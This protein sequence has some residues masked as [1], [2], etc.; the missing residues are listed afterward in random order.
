MMKVSECLK[1]VIVVFAAAA[2][3]LSPAPGTA[4]TSLAVGKTASATGSAFFG[5]TN[6]ADSCGAIRT[7]VY[8]A[9]T[10]K[11]GETIA[12]PYLEYKYGGEGKWSYTFSHDSH[13]FVATPYMPYT[14]T[15]LKDDAEVYHTAGINE[16]G[17]STSATNTTNLRAAAQVKDN[18]YAKAGIDESF[19][20]MIILAEAKTAEEGVAL[21]GR[22]IEKEG[23]GDACGFLIYIA[24]KKGIWVLET[25][26]RHRWVASKLPDDRFIIVANDMVTDFV[27]LDDRDNFRGTADVKRFAIDNGFAVYGSGVHAGEVN[28]AASY[29]KINDQLFNAHRRWRGY[30]LF[31]PSQVKE[32]LSGDTVTYPMF[33][34]PDKKISAAD[35]MALQRD[36]YQGTSFDISEIRRS[37]LDRRGYEYKENKE[38][39]D[40][41]AWVRP[42]GHNTTQTAHILEID[43]KLPD[44]VGARLWYC[45]SQPE[46][47]VYLPYYGNITDTHPYCKTYVDGNY[48]FAADGTR[49]SYPRCQSDSCYFI[50]QDLGFRARENRAMYGA[51]IKAYWRAYE[52]KLVAEQKA[53]TDK[54][55]ELYGGAAPLSAEYIT[56]YTINTAQRAMNRAGLMRRELIKH[57]KKAPGTLFTVPSDA[58]PYVNADLLTYRIDGDTEARSVDA[59]LKLASG[60]AVQAGYESPAETAELDP[61]GAPA[62]PGRQA[63]SAGGVSLDAEL[64]GG[65][66]FARVKY[67]VELIGDDYKKFACSTAK[68]SASFAIYGGGAEL[69]G[70]RGVVTMSEAEKAGIVTVIGDGDG[71]TVTADFYLY[72]GKGAAVCAGGIFALPDGLGD[73]RLKDSGFWSYAAGGSES[74]DGY[75]AGWRPGAACGGP[76]LCEA[77]S[78]SRA[79]AF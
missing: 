11:K 15:L 49:T 43:E 68:V 71:A 35:A 32:V 42:I 61:A 4:C 13:R 2:F 72:D 50:F 5:R 14:A 25:A 12:N 76:A 16:Y 59:A 34:L 41:P 10:F 66:N 73:G 56:K 36:R 26:G 53:V 23:V 78:L 75:G 47:S 30:N 65:A 40:Y 7:K 74:S 22:I 63:L 28:I 46:D 57:V 44:A 39:L 8:P 52:L 6:D 17:V 62:L 18:G 9:G 27:D 58:T 33:V 67:T 70:P 21:V 31:A 60:T 38:N 45:M 54:M 24:D 51:P 77:C 48:V 19:T 20:A 3:L 64:R 69:I 1:K 29:G 55:L 37:K 79:A